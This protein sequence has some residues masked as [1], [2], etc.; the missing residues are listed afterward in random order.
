MPYVPTKLM[1]TV[2]DWLDVY[3]TRDFTKRQS[4][5]MAFLLSLTLR[6]GG[7]KCYVPKLSDFEQ[8]GIS[9]TKIRVELQKLIDL[10][11]IVWDREE[12]IFYINPNTDEWR[13]PTVKMYKENKYKALVDAN[14]PRRSP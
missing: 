9:R 5:I 10:K 11:V 6:Q 2:L 1:N 7:I 14:T 8:C 3:C 13:T 12:M 4:R